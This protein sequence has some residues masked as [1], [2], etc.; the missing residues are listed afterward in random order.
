MVMGEEKM[1][2]AEDV[3]SENTE[4][5]VRDIERKLGERE[6]RKKG[7]EEKEATPGKIAKQLK[8]K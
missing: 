5:E 7:E 4:E 1:D 2:E 3:V 8:Q 6:E